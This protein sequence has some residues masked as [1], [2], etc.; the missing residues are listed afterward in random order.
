MS[1]SLRIAYQGIKIRQRSTRYA[2]QAALPRVVKRR[3][4]ENSASQYSYPV[5]PPT[6]EPLTIKD[7]GYAQFLQNAEFFNR[8]ESHTYLPP[9]QLVEINKTLLYE[10]AHD[11][12][13][14]AH[15]MR[16]LQQKI[17]ALSST[18]EKILRLI[19]S[20]QK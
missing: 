2:F 15:E 10:K 17:D 8:H 20:Q 18:I 11:L 19:S 13:E 7:P 16:S 1:T 9:L 3:F 14:I 5:G 12:K 6:S 4:S